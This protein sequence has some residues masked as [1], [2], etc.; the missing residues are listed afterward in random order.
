MHKVPENEGNETTLGG[1]KV[2]PT[3]ILPK[4]LI[5]PTGACINRQHPLTNNIIE[6]LHRQLRRNRLHRGWDAPPKFNA[7]IRHSAEVRLAGVTCVPLN[8][9]QRT[10]LS[11]DTRSL[12]NLP[13]CAAGRRGLPRYGRSKSQDGK[14]FV[15]L[16]V[17]TTS[18]ACLRP[19]LKVGPVYNSESNRIKN[20]CCHFKPSANA[21]PLGN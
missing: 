13:F 14:G 6:R 10:S 11:A 18:P 16:D 9:T 5:Y 17:V 3:E 2:F 21:F 8:P 1:L 15:Q 7:I 20:S 12:I 4:H 19:L